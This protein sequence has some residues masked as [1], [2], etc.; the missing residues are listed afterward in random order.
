MCLYGAPCSL[1]FAAVAASALTRSCSCPGRMMSL[2]SRLTCSSSSSSSS[3]SG[4]SSSSW[5]VHQHRMARDVPRFMNNIKSLS[6]GQR[7]CLNYLP[8]H[9]STLPCQLHAQQSQKQFCCNC[10]LLTAAAKAAAIPHHPEG[11][12]PTAFPAAPTCWSGDSSKQQVAGSVATQPQ[13]HPHQLAMHYPSHHS[14]P[15]PVVAAANS[16]QQ[17]LLRAWLQS[18]PQQLATRY[19]PQ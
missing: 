4:S 13:S 1:V 19:K 2:K 17:V 6:S 18:Q 3:S 11:P 12:K 8:S 16:G 9:S 5:V 14:L 15:N 7:C 10:L